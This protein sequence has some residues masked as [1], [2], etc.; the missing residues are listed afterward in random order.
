MQL[1]LGVSDERLQQRND[2]LNVALSSTQ[3]VVL[4]STSSVCE[5]DLRLI[6]TQHL[7]LVRDI[8]KAESC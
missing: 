8:R 4:S 5:G 6:E 2:M 7:S 3:S 1:G